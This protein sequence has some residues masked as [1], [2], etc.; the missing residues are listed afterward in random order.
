MLA[1]W[2]SLH[3]DIVIVIAYGK[4]LPQEILKLAPQGCINVHFS[5]LPKYR[6]AAPINWAI[7]NDEGE[8]GVTTMVVTPEMD[9]GPIL[10]QKKNRI[11]PEDTAEILGKRLASV[12]AE[13][14]LE[15]LA[16][17]QDH[18]L[19]PIAQNEREVILAPALKKENGLIPWEQQA[20]TLIK[21][22]HGVTPWPGAYTF[23][24]RSGTGVDKERL[25]IYSAE[26]VGQGV[27][28]N[29]GEILAVT[30]HGLEIA[31]GHGVLLLTEVQPEGK[32]RMTIRDY[33]NG[34]KVTAGMRFVS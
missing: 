34:H 9:A 20:A 4:Y 21:L 5:L 31:C 30:S 19:K 18:R 11:L 13:L 16:D 12:G 2:Q 24:D 10:K 32:R 14:L 33:V 15:T 25:K 8:T 28:K 7:I 17:L 3:P 23:L 22:I 26:A 1:T 29:P 6:G 27:H